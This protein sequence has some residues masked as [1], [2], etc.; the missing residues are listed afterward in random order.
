MDNVV[1]LVDDD[2]NIL[3]GLA[4]VLRDQPYRLYTARS[5]NEAQLIIK[6]HSVDVIVSD[7]QMP[8]MCG[9]DLLTWVAGNCH[10]VMRIMLTGRPSAETAIRAIN[11]GAVYQFFTKPCD[12][13][14][15][16]VAI[17]KALERRALLIE[18]RQ[19]LDV[20]SRQM[21]QLEHYRRDLEALTSLV[22]RDIQEPLQVVFRS[23][24]SL[25]EQYRDIVDPKTA[26][27]VENALNSIGDV[28]RLV[29]QLQ[30]HCHTH[31]P[32]ICTNPSQP[33]DEMPNQFPGGLCPSAVVT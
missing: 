27:L 15:L 22:F 14:L 25:E 1:L 11:E 24:Q 4:R 19:L 2:P 7:E 6:S 30:Q 17:R 31:R 28:Q 9:N 5:G 13:A 8:G 33:D 16:A 3:H 10:E 12:P 29:S 32:P 20:N 21:Q 26:T 23:C 18:N